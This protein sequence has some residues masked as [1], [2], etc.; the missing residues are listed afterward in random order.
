MGRS[1]WR[2]RRVRGRRNRLRVRDGRRR[3]GGLAG[4]AA[5]TRRSAHGTG[6]RDDGTRH[7]RGASRC[8]RRRVSMRR[9]RCVGAGVH[10]LRRGGRPPVRG[11]RLHRRHRAGAR[12]CRGLGGLTSAVGQRRGGRRGRRG[13]IRDGARHH[14]A[15]DDCRG[16]AEHEGGAPRCQRSR[17]A[18]HNR[19]RPARSG[20]ARGIASPFGTPLGGARTVEVPTRSEDR[21]EPGRRHSV[22]CLLCARVRALG[23]RQIAVLLQ[24]CAQVESGVL[25]AAPLSASVARFCLT[26]LSPRLVQNAEVQ[27]RARVTERVGLAVGELGAGWVAARFEK[28]TEAKLLNGS[29]R[30]VGHCVHAPRHLPAFPTILATTASADAADWVSLDPFEAEL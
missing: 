22:T 14:R 6:M 18:G 2:R 11:A 19:A 20:C 27:R 28:H 3:R 16:C 25:I 9:T 23:A 10:R 29:T 13:R 5:R 7:M 17:T 8:L 26:E 12:S 4:A 21:G 1:G 24:K 30:A 15:D